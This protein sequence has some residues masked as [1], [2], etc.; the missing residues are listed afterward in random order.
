MSASD[1]YEVKRIAGCW[2][3]E[4]GA[5]YLIE[6]DGYK[7]EQ[8]TWEPLE[9]LLGNVQLV[10]YFAQAYNA[11]NPTNKYVPAKLGKYL[12]KDTYDPLAKFEPITNHPNQ[13]ESSSSSSTSNKKSNKSKATTLPA[14]NPRPKKQKIIEEKPPKNIRIESISNGQMLRNVVIKTPVS[15]GQ[16]AISAVIEDRN[17]ANKLAEK[18]LINHTEAIAQEHPL[19]D[20][21]LADRRKFANVYPPV[22]V[23]NDVDGQEFPQLFTY[24]DDFLYGENVNKPDPDFL[25]SCDCD[26]VCVTQRNIG[27]HE[28]QAYRKTGDLKIGF[29]GAIVECNMRCPCDKNCYNRVVQRGRTKPLVIYRTKKKGWGVRATVDIKERTFVEQY[30]GEVISQAEGDR[31]GKIYDKM[32]TSYLFDMDLAEGD[33]NLS[34]K[35]VIDSYIYGNASH[36]FNHSCNPNLAVYGTFYDSADPTFH[37]LAFF[38]KRHIKRGEELTFDYCGNADLGADVSTKIQ[39]GCGAKECRKWIHR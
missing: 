32:G 15:S 6:W 39:C 28:L 10:D 13:N 20:D 7:K 29:D 37:R 12:L 2:E 21:P 5:T 22:Y 36:F 33:Q 35:H 38:S 23:E 8:N 24:V 3:T 14:S 11:E 17:E 26:R 18:L 4:E 19:I 31:R 9:N 34:V 25:N 27:C 1:E 16:K 30:I